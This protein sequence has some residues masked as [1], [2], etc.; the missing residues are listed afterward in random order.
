MNRFPYHLPMSRR[1]LPTQILGLIAWL[2]LAFITATVGAVASVEAGSFYGQLLRP[3]WAPPPASAFGPVW[4][5]LYLLM[6]LSAWLVAWRE[7]GAPGLRAALGL[8]VTQLCV[9]RSG[10]GCSSSGTRGLTP[11]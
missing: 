10:P 7:R 9:K 2:A 1:S 5:T 6:G 4:T 8:F 3:D 11:S